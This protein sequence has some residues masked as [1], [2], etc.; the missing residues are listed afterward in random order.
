MKELVKHDRSKVV[1]LLDERLAF[2]RA[3]LKL[4]DRVLGAMRA[5][6]DADVRGLEGEM[7]TSRN[8]EEEHLAWLE[9]QLRALRPDSGGEPG[10][11]GGAEGAR[12]VEEVA[13]SDVPLPQLVNA[14]LAAKLADDAGWD[15]LVQ[16]AAEARDLDARRELRRRLHEE[17]DHVLVI[18]RVMAK[19]VFNE[20]LAE[21]GTSGAP[22]V[23]H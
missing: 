14:L 8:E 19:L 3:G 21:E 7:E 23:T 9:A 6:G 10:D 5:F 20:V 11:P 15:G 18:R 16:L 1:H 13:N 22:G 17:E 4:Y 12:R 2:E